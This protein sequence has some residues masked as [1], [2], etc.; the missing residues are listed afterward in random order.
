M[1][2]QTARLISTQIS[3]FSALPVSGCLLFTDTSIANVF[4]SLS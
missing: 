2:F 4:V 1:Q 3:A